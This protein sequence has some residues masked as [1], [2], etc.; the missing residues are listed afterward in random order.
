[1]P[2]S[3]SFMALPPTR[4][5]SSG[6]APLK[7]KYRGGRSPCISR[8]STPLLLPP[9]PSHL[10]FAYIAPMG[11]TSHTLISTVSKEEFPTSTRS[12]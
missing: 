4:Q 8:A 10:P 3:R 1:M 5:F 12:R 7:Y 2:K 11:S 9:T 6:S